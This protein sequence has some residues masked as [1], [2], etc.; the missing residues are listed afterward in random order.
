MLGWALPILKNNIIIKF[1][2]VTLAIM[3][4]QIVTLLLLK[5]SYSGLRS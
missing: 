1:D 3:M 2:L 4:V 5:N